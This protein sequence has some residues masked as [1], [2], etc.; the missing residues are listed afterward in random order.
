MASGELTKVLNVNY[1]SLFNV[2]TDF[3]KYPEFVPAVKNVTVKPVGT[4]TKDIG[5]LEGVYQVSFMKDFEYKLKLSYDRAAGKVR[6]SLLESSVFKTNNGGW[7]L[8]RISDTQTEVRYFVDVE[9]KIMVPGFILNG[10]VKKDL[11]NMI[12]AFA[13]RTSNV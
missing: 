12:A 1:D 7:D 4:V 3:P 11:P 9:F 13:E 8:K 2:V 6:W 5:E 10:L